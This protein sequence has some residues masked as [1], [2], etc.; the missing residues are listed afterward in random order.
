MTEPSTKI[1]SAPAPDFV[2][3]AT[4][5]HETLE[6][7]VSGIDL[8]PPGPELRIVPTRHHR[9]VNPCRDRPVHP[10][11]RARY[12]PVR[13]AAPYRLTHVRRANPTWFLSDRPATR[14]PS[15][16]RTR[17]SPAN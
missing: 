6:V 15:P 10:A 14:G 13:R 17:P 12:R 7:L 3:S 4:H 5:D 16:E 8:R 11:I 2:G 9:R 1:V